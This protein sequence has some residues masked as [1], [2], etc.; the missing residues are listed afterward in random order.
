MARALTGWR[1]DWRD[2]VGHDELPLRPRV[3][4]RQAQADLRPPRRASTGAT[5]PTSRSATSCTRAS[6]SRKLW[7]YFIPTP[8][9]PATRR[10]LAA[11]LQALGP[12]RAPGARRDPAPS[13]APRRPADGQAA[14]RLHRR[15]C[16]ARCGRGIDTDAWA[17]LTV[18]ERPDAVRSRRTSPAGTT[19]AGSTPRPGA[20]AGWSRTTRSRAARSTRTRR[21]RATR[22]AQGEPRARPSTPRTASGAGPSLTPRHRARAGRLRPARRAPAADEPWK[23]ES[24]AILRQNALRMLIATSPD[25]H[26]S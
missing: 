19:R 11:A 3:P 15:A 10:A 5:P 26:T 24:Y 25:L 1:A 6:S 22:H 14:G 2:G 12:R 4:R 8:P 9:P 20:G 21:R 13:G 16:C 17:W 18:D 23:R 7:S